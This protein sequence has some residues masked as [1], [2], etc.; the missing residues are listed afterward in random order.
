MLSDE[1]IIEGIHEL[2]EYVGSSEWCKANS[3]SEV[4]RLQNMIVD[5]KIELEERNLK[6]TIDNSKKEK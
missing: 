6:F 2:R 4:R 3:R 5:M 1:R